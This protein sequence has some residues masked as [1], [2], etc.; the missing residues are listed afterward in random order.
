MR[1]IAGRL[2][3]RRLRAPRGAHV[4]P[5]SD[6]VREA[7]FAMLASVEGAVVLDLF[8]GTGALGIEALSRD[9]G[10]ATFVERDR[11]TAGVLRENLEAL[12]LGPDIAEVRACDA[13][14]ALRAARERDEKYDLV[15]IDPPYRGAGAWSGRLVET[16]P[17]LLAPGARIVVESDRRAPLE[18]ETDLERDRLYG[19]TSIR[20]H[21]HR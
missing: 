20:I 10:R 6:R 18:L 15:F 13:I 11:A 8:A 4:R 1:V 2:G 17:P 3:G 7:I 9:A 19:D 16:L 14:Q 5:T 21:R 12:G